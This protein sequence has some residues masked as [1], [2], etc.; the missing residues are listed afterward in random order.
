MNKV[1]TSA[2]K[3][4]E[5]I[6]NGATLMIGGFGLCGIP[7]NLIG[8]LVRSGRSGFHTISNNMGVDDFGIGLMLAAGQ[9][10]SH[11]GSYVGERS[12][13]HTSELQSPC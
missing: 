6:P 13:E 1:F 5:D 2:D 9:I 10:A 7:E 3:A 11:V 4:I 12:E 8:A